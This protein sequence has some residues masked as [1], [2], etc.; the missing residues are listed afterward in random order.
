MKD[1]MIDSIDERVINEIREI[2]GSP[3]Y[4]FDEVSFIN[5]FNNL[6]NT[7]RK[8]YPKYRI[9]YSYKTNYTPYIGRLVHRL[10]GLA[11]VVSDFEL[12]A[13]LKNGN[14]YNNIIYNG[15]LKQN[16]LEE[17]AING[18]IVNIDNIQECE[19]IIGI[20]KNNPTKN[21]SV[22]LRVNINVGQ[23]FISRFG[24]D[25]ETEDF[26]NALSLLR[27]QHNIDLCGLHCHVGQSRSAENWKLRV[28]KMLEISDRIFGETP[29]KYIDLGSGMFGD[30][31][32]QFKVQ[33]GDN[34]PTYDDY[35]KIVAKAFS[36]HFSF[37]DDNIK[38]YLYTEPG[39][40]VASRYMWLLTTITSH[41]C[42]KGRM[43]TGVDSSYFNA[44]ETCRYKKLPIR[45]IG[46]QQDFVLG[47]IVGYTCLE[48]DCLYPD[49]A[50]TASIGDIILLGNTGGYSLVF[51]PPFILPDAPAI[52]LKEDFTHELIK[53]EQTFENMLELYI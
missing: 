34:V 30:M 22:G 10:G 18:G 26:E 50:Q 2:Y 51:K 23:D 11:E 20:A 48:D 13:A 25:P 33:F 28:S 36:E 9:A 29:P 49:C 40:T 19:R 24:I 17:F 32:P 7:F 45:I 27:N 39:A 14:Q 3:V 6:Q 46:K 38:P 35:A 1:R 5:N 44:G 15:P 8:Y 47:D 43:V 42:V 21:I 53:R 4:I 37:C 12:Y 41:K 52:V 16:L 31:E